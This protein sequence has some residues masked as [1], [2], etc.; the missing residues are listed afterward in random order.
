MTTGLKYE[1]KRHIKKNK[2][3]I[4]KTQTRNTEQHKADCQNFFTQIRPSGV[5]IICSG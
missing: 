1:N 3:K 4:L 5:T 2:L